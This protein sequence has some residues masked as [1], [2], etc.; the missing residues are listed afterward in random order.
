MPDAG[1]VQIGDSLCFHIAG[2][3]V[4]GR[5]RVT[6]IME[7]GSGIRD[8]RRFRQILRLAD[9]TLHRDQPIA[10]DP[11]I[12]LRLRAIPLHG[13]RHTQTLFAIS[14]ECFVSM[15]ATRHDEPVDEG[16]RLTG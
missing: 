14:Y 15:T 4:V 13:R 3:G 7:D 8:A 2:K 16:Q 10:L 12:E 9:V 11:E 6:S 1:P 5:A